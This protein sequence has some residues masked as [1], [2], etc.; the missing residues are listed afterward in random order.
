MK[1]FQYY[2]NW[3]IN[4]LKNQLVEE[5]AVKKSLVY[6]E[7]MLEKSFPVGTIREW[8]GKKYKKVA[9]GK[10][11][12]YYNSQNRGSNQALRYAI[13][14]LEKIEDMETLAKF[15]NANRNRFCNEYGKP[16][17]E[18]EEILKL[19]YEKAED[20]K[21]LGNNVKRTFTEDTRNKAYNVIN[22]PNE[23]MLFVE[24]TRENFNKFFPM[25][26]VK[27]PIGKVKLSPHQFERLGE[28]DNGAR[29]D[30]IG[31]LF[32]TLTNPDVIIGKTDNRGRYGKIFL[33]AFIDNNG[34]KSYLALVPN[35]DGLDIVVS[36]GPRDTKDIAKEIKK[37][38]HY[39]YINES[40]LMTS[41]ISGGSPMR[42]PD[43]GQISNDSRNEK[44]TKPSNN[45][46]LMSE[47]EIVNKDSEK[48]VKTECKSLIDLRDYAKNNF[49]IDVKVTGNSNTK[50][51]DV[52][53]SFYEVEKMCKKLPGLNEYIKTIEYDNIGKKN[54]GVYNPDEYKIRIGNFQ[55]NAEFEDFKFATGR[56][57]TTVMQHEMTHAI[58]QYIFMNADEEDFR[59]MFENSKLGD[60]HIK[61]NRAKYKT[62]ED[63]KF[64]MPES[65]D[66]QKYKFYQSKITK[67][68]MNK[69]FKN[70]GV[71]PIKFGQKKETL[72]Y[73]EQNPETGKYRYKKDSFTPEEL[74]VLNVSF[75]SL[76]DPVELWSEAFTDYL[77]NGENA[78]P[79]SKEIWK[80]VN[81]DYLNGELNKSFLYIMKSILGEYVA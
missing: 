72:H 76:S 75:Y 34:E 53:D 7:L 21:D 44:D 10:W 24:Y 39:Y 45:S 38:D 14:Q 71:K 65:F 78:Q 77:Q 13:K 11:M 1:D 51:E 2:K 79:I 28:K 74:S 50:L 54:N 48:S 58:Q 81:E 80:I 17:P 26:E 32:Q 63:Y 8:K 40:A 57:V 43:E 41:I 6:C 23:K 15:I 64:N 47:K 25:G 59:D 66:V 56:D 36:N 61:R 5:N 70:L 69:A 18:A 42:N 29:K 4:H 68:I 31:A 9:P 35:I 27:T 62:L 52:I 30:Y 55:K 12:R 16:L 20:I 46:N 49:D 22:N 33:K 37:A 60:K 3:A 19:G 73:I 67:D